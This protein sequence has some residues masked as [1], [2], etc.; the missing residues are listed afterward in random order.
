MTRIKQPHW[1]LRAGS[2]KFL[3][4][5]YTSLFSIFADFREAFGLFD[6]SGKGSITADDLKAVLQS[7]G[8]NPSEDELRDM[9]REV[10]DDGKCL[11]CCCLVG[12][13]FH[14]LVTYIS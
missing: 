9:I 10:D 6:R 1:V 12:F 13:S 5:S 3:S 14:T 11:Y 2:A 4:C 8:Q 7:L